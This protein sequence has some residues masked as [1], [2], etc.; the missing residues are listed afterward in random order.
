LS[1]VIVWPGKRWMSIVNWEKFMYFIS[2][3]HRNG[4]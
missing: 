1:N 4:D 3:K 2:E